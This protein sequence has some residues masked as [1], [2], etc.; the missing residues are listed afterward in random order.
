LILDADTGKVDDVNP[1]LLQLLGYSYDALCGKH[2][3]EIGVFKDIVASKD[4]F[5]TL[6][7][8]EYIR[9]NDLSLET[10]DGRPIA[11][12]FVSNVYLVDH[13]KVIQ[14]NIRD[15][16]EHKRM[17]EE[18]QKLLVSAKLERDRLSSLI[19][20][21]SDEIWFADADKR[22]TLMNPAVN[23]EFGSSV[24]EG[25][26]VEKIAASFEVYRSDGTP[27]PVDEAPP[28][29][30]LRGEVVVNEKE[31]VLIPT[32][33]E[34]RTREVSAAPVKDV[35]GAII[36][37]VSVVRDITERKLVEEA[38]RGS[39]DRFRLVL[40]ASSMGTFEV[41][42][43]TGE[44]Q[45]NA[46]EFELLGL[47]PG[48]VVAGPD[49]FFRFVHP[50]DVERLGNEWEEA[51]RS[52]KFDAE[53][54]I[55]RTDGHERW[56]AGKGTFIFDG[57]SDGRDTGTGGKPRRFMGV[58][59]DITERKKAEE[60][61][62][63][64]KEQAERQAER[65]AAQLAATLD[66]APAI[67][68]T[69]HDRDCRSITGNRAAH[70][71]SR[72]PEGIDLSKTGPHPELLANYRIFH[73][74]V[75]LQPQDMPVQVVARTG[76]ELQGYTI[77][78]LFDDGSIRSL[79]GN[80]IPVLDACGCPTGAIAAFMDIT[81]RMRAEEALRQSEQIYRTIGEALDYG[82][83]VCEPDGGERYLSQS[84]LDLV[85]M[86]E[87][88]V[89]QFGWTTRLPPEDVE[90][91]IQKWTECCRLAG[92]WDT[93][94]RI[95]GTDGDYRTILSR[96]KP[97]FNRNG[98]ITAWAGINLDITERKRAEHEL[99]R[100]TRSLE[101]ANKELESFSYSVSHDLKAPLR[102][103]DGYSRMLARKC[104]SKLDED[105]VR[106]ISVIR[107]NTE[108]MGILIDDLLSFSRVAR[109][110][111]TLL[112]ID[113]DTLVSDVWSDIQVTHR[114]RELELKPAKLIPGFGDRALVRQVL[115]NLI[116]NAVK[117]TK[118][119]QPGIIELSSYAENGNAVYCVKDN[120]VG[121]DMAFYDK[122]FGIFQRLHSDEE[123]EG[124]G[125][126]LAIVNRIINRHG[127]RVW[128]EAKVD[129]GAT[130]CFSLPLP[131]RNIGKYVK[132]GDSPSPL[133]H[134]LF[135]K[136]G[137]MG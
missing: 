90:P 29:R 105:A 99:K 133:V 106:M 5:K 98:E 120:G 15:V 14:C 93:E 39:E 129:E 95:M 34:T 110:G 32:R 101:D 82:I 6:Q 55:V 42:L 91:T 123:Y 78:F 58:N 3:W 134:P 2:I 80:V 30:A 130:F 114:E 88:E 72:V 46:T 102:A 53:F 71:F 21:I 116:S 121:F 113:M 13:H 50:D 137:Y 16:T 122:L 27:R 64:S 57:H 94:H 26:E 109:N 107:G 111:L 19:G 73:D 51:M 135:P 126:G 12:E 35:N 45:W 36:G 10:C 86:T 22:L 87:S 125:V 132:N 69:A 108:K 117:F 104:E 43:L 23:N 37:S 11:V 83:W 115:F 60:A 63:I 77:D 131:P 38:L 68:W 103:I 66:A 31:I 127:G 79:I 61:L 84:F 128:A 59:F 9:Y 97:I 49:A 18:N 7:E 54:R 96:G 48:E 20:S 24:V 100:Q 81:E 4:A 25:M 28:L 89:K 52:G 74:G 85:G 118:A 41:D 44:G 124:T 47:R 119:R 76:Q 40:Q 56:L 136:R 112:E 65:Q 1:F 17:E 33:G 92:V 75:E 70:E 8:D 67:I 62:G